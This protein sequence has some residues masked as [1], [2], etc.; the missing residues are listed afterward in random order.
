MH[1]NYIFG[2]AYRDG[3]PGPEPAGTPRVRKSF[4]KGVRSLTWPGRAG[5]AAI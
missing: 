1:V 2:A 5:A 3:P 4:S